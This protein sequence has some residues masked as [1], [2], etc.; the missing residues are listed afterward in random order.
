MWCGGGGREERGEKRGRE[1]E[2][3]GRID[4]GA[5][6]WNRQIAKFHWFMSCSPGDGFLFLS[7]YSLGRT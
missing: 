7:K 5:A 1:R 6:A 3:E 4:A 2:G